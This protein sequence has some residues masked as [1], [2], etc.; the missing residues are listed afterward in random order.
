MYEKFGTFLL[1]DLVE[2]LRLIIC[3]IAKR[4]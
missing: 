3:Y 4:K 1:E 2:A